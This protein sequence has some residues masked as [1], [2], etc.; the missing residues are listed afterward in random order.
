MNETNSIRPI[1][2][3]N[4]H[5]PKMTTVESDELMLLTHQLLDS[6]AAAD[7]ETYADLCDE[8]LTAYEPEARGHRVVG[9]PFHQFYFEAGPAKAV[10]TSI[11]DPHVRLMGDCAVVTYVRL[12]QRATEQGFVSSRFEETRVWQR[13]DG[14]WQHVHFH[15]SAND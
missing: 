1:L 10:Q 15:R 13:Q 9:M 3:S 5:E 12:V 11:I 7:W 2:F 14:R 6:I 4:A 8:T